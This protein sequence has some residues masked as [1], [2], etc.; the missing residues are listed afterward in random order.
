MVDVAVTMQVGSSP[1]FLRLYYIL[2]L[3]RDN[4]WLRSSTK[5]VDFMFL[6]DNIGTSVLLNLRE[7]DVSQLLDLFILS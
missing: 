2:I 7:S 4:A 3:A 6:N 1:A 5:E